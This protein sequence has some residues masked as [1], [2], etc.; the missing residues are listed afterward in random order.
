MVSFWIYP[1]RYFIGPH[2][3]CAGRVE[4]VWSWLSTPNMAIG[5]V[6]T[7]SRAIQ[8]SESFGNIW[9][10][11][12]W[13]SN[14]PLYIIPNFTEPT[15]STNMRAALQQRKAN[16]HVCWSDGKCFDFPPLMIQVLNW[17]CNFK[18]SIFPGENFPYY[19]S[20]FKWVMTRGKRQ[21]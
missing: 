3:G 18:Y 13:F 21:R 4:T 10:I 12:Q 11:H 6:G 8:C 2:S 15:I 16:I 7:F 17:H 14:S 20:I 5:I 9:Q 19:T 1:M